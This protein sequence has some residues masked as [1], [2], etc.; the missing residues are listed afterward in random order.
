[1]TVLRQPVTL[2]APFLG[3]P[4]PV[5]QSVH[6][7]PQGWPPA[8]SLRL[9]MI[10]ALFHRRETE[11]REVQHLAQGHAALTSRLGGLRG[12]VLAS[13]AAAPTHCPTRSQGPLT[14]S[15]RAWGLN[16]A[17]Q[18]RVLV[19]AGRRNPK[20]RGGGGGRPRSQASWEPG[21][22]LWHPCG[23][24][25]LAAAPAKIPVQRPGSCQG[26]RSQEAALGPPH[27]SKR[28]VSLRPVPG[29]PGTLS[30]SP[31]ICK[32]QDVPAVP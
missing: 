1:M 22:G 19:S 32:S 3:T 24:P 13:D 9:L 23:G 26:T 28:S 17:S 8:R 5:L 16:V 25:T 30:L 7:P 18:P 10:P 14:G 4:G 29:T 11:A 21:R 15:A 2:V 12:L 6:A 20:T 27:T 31:G